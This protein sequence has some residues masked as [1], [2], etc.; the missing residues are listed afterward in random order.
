M[1]D[2]FTFT[3]SAP[4]IL[5]AADAASVQE[6][7]LMSSQRPPT[8]RRR[9]TVPV[10][11]LV[12]A[13]V[14]GLPSAGSAEQRDPKAVEIAH[15]MLDAM[16][17]AEA[18]E[19]TRFI[20]FNFFGFRTH[21][22]DRY[23]GRHRLEGK[24]RDGDAYVVVH[25][26]NTREGS[27]YLNGEA[28][29]GDP[30]AE[31][32]ENAYGAYINDTYWLVMPYKLLDPGVNLVYD[33]EETL[34]RTGCHKLKLTFDG[35]GLTPGDTY[36]A[37]VNAETGVMERWSYWLESWEADRE[38]TQW[39]WTDWA[40]Y[41]GILLSPSRVQVP[42]GDQQLLSDIAVFDHLPDS[43]FES[44]DPVQLD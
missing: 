5:T 21:H 8:P 28:L 17:G 34:D 9:R 1:M 13:L 3:L 25:N 24:T 35:V 19:S 30:K 15:L 41:G 37:Y 14:S 31:W 23:T 4:S 40:T 22:W 36:W 42:E 44:K 16:G 27:A 38:P 18:W 33:G 2:S 11:C 26:V 10:A 7:V 29:E 39:K 6:N 12:L 20:R 43:V 32:L